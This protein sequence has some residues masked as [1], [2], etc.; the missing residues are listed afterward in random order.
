MMDMCPLLPDSL[1]PDVKGAICYQFTVSNH[2]KSL[3]IVIQKGIVLCRNITSFENN[4]T[5]ITR[6]EITFAVA[7]FD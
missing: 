6:M 4:A 2:E 3:Y 7:V 5:A 1:L